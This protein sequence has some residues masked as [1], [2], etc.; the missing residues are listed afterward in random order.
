M[1]GGPLATK[2]LERLL[3]VYV[4]PTTEEAGAIDR[5]HEAYLDRFKAEIDPE[6]KQL[7]EEGGRLGAKMSIQD[8]RKF[9][10]E[11][12]RLQ[13]KVAAADGAFFDSASAILPEAKRAGLT[14]VSD[15][16]ARQREA[17]GL[18]RMAP[19]ILGQTGNFV[20]LA[21]VLA[22]PQ[23]AGEVPPE[24]RERFDA[25]MRTQEQRLLVQAKRYSSEVAKSLD[26]FIDGMLSLRNAAVNDAEPP[27]GEPGDA[28][29][30]AAA[31]AAALRKGMQQS[32]ERISALQQQTG[33]AV[34]EQVAAN[35]KANRA[36]ISELSSILP[37]TKLFD[38]RA[39]LAQRASGDAG[40]FMAAGFRVGA[41]DPAIAAARI[42]RSAAV[43][44]EAKTAVVEALAVWKR[45]NAEAIEARTDAIL[46]FGQDNRSMMR[47]RSATEFDPGREKIIEAETRRLKAIQRAYTAMAAAIGDEADTFF[48]RIAPRP[49]GGEIELS[50][51]MSREEV[52]E[53]QQSSVPGGNELLIFASQPTATS[54]TDIVRKLTALGVGRDAL[55]PLDG[56]LEAWRAREFE[57]KLA[58]IS[59]EY[60]AARES[61]YA[62][63]EQGVVKP[64][65]EKIRQSNDL[66]NRFVKA[67]FEVDHALAGDLAGAIGLEAEG[68]EMLALRLEMIELLQS[69]NP[70]GEPVKIVSPLRIVM[71]ARVDP[72]VARAVFA[73]APGK[74]RALAADLERLCLE[75]LARRRSVSEPADGPAAVGASRLDRGQEITRLMREINDA[76]TDLRKRLAETFDEATAAAC[77]D[78]SVCAQLRQSR[79]RLMHPGYFK[80][81]DC[82][83]RQLAQ[84]M[85][86]DGLAE[87]QRARL[88]ALKAEYDAVFMT[89]TE[90]MIEVSTGDGVPT[91]SDGFRRAQ[92]AAEEVEKL[93]FQ[94]SERTAKARSEARR[95]LGD[96]LAAEIRGLV[97]N[98]SEPTAQARRPVAGMMF[99]S[100]ADDDE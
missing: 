100:A 72:A 96:E 10:R 64:N 6:L 54:S 47:F 86:L 75:M 8:F 50:L 24:A 79:L 5:L 58:A 69:T 25:F 39:D 16:R 82:A 52:E 90:K 61:S 3:T 57:P 88:D 51:V 73:S 92:Q 36:A 48:S 20:D 7:T 67:Y 35:F 38:L 56:V 41:G 70:R 68:P 44:A 49:D 60:A 4:A 18:S 43:S 40:M 65:P 80:R 63:D 33:G 19:M 55:T 81:S 46:E 98:D 91:D 37:E 89:I 95:I 84:A 14:R 34:R 13:A 21:D 77:P 83:T 76:S 31:E 42:K 9:M 85:E 99:Q 11:V 28:A 29:A 62:M 45:E 59:R 78:P 15:A 17:A 66:L 71:D 27:R 32:M 23:Y 97:P 12:D 1:V 53:D 22:R 74:W 30:D 26:T 93:R 2:R 87:D 94:R